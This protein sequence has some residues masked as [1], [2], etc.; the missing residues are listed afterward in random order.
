MLCRFSGNRQ[1]TSALACIACMHTYVTTAYVIKN[2]TIPALLVSPL[3][4]IDDLDVQ[5]CVGASREHCVSTPYYVQSCN[6]QCQNVTRSP[7]TFATTK[8]T[9]LFAHMLCPNN[10]DPNCKR[11]LIAACHMRLFAITGL[12]AFTVSRCRSSQ[13]HLSL[14]RWD[15]FRRKLVQA[16]LQQ[17]KPFMDALQA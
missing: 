17:R 7:V 10:H 14:L 6:G 8:R 3:N 15:Y 12:V 9:C 2:P 13:A 16:H 11:K 1:T 4:H 5:M